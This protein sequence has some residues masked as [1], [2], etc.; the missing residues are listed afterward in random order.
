MKL[1]VTPAPHIRDKDTTQSIMLDVIIALLPALIASVVIFGVRALIVTAV[2][3]I[4]AVLSEFLF[5]KGV[6]KPITIQDLSA[7]VTGILLAFCL[8]VDIPLWIAALGG[9]IAIVVV[10]Q[11]F[12]G[13]GQ[14]FA[15]PAAT[16]RVILLICS[17]GGA[18][19]TWTLDG[20]SVATPL[21]EGAAVPR[22]TTLFL[23]L[24]GGCLGETCSAALLIGGIYLLIRKIIS[25]HIPVAYLGTVAII[26]LAGGQDLTLQLLGGGLLLGAF[27]M[28]TDYTTSPMTNE[29]KLVYGVGCG[30]LTMMIRLWGATPEGVSYAILLMNILTPHIDKL[31]AHTPLG[32]DVK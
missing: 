23:G 4:A 30:V 15:N 12:G 29:G 24:H 6:K 17:F 14:N 1:L 18:M 31:T 5:E 10:K 25:W 13:I 8:P 22:L 21:A 26:Y 19:T 32:G 28:A 9:V 3:V 11:L 7:V 2:C 20:V 16:A 27:F